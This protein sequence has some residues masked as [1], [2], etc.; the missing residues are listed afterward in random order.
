MPGATKAILIDAPIEK[1]FGIITDY[2][3]YVEFLPE[4]KKI[5]ISAR[6]GNQVDV[7]HE[8]AMIKT[9]RYTLRLTEDKPSRVSWSLVKG[10]FMREN[11]GSWLLEAQGDGQTQATYS[12]EMT[13][14]PLVPRAIVNALVETSLPKMLSAFKGRAEAR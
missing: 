1:V 14:G 2:E 5:Q 10:E 13:F 7:E 12:I 9:V 11:R 3:K 8:V 4:V 6:S